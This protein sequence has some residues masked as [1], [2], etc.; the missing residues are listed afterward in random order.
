MEI[1]NWKGGLDGML[2]CKLKH[3]SAVHIHYLKNDFFI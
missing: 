1:V 2:S 3:N